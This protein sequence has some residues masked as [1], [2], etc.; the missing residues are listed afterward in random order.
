MCELVDHSVVNVINTKLCSSTMRLI[1][2]SNTI[3]V[4]TNQFSNYRRKS[5]QILQKSVIGNGKNYIFSH[6]EGQE[7]NALLIRASFV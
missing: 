6:V 3:L 4:D 1:N 2:F 5:K 7:I